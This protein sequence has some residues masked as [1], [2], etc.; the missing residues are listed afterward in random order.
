MASAEGL[1]AQLDALLATTVAQ[2]AFDKLGRRLA[3]ALTGKTDAVLRPLQRDAT[4]AGCRGACM[5][6]CTL[7]VCE[8]M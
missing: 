8:P 4:M 1:V 3:V 7:G 2:E 6:V 5:V